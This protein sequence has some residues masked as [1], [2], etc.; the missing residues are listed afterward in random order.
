MQYS[1][2]VEIDGAIVRIIEPIFAA[3]DRAALLQA[4]DRKGLFPT[5]ARLVV[6]RGGER[7]VTLEVNRRTEGAVSA[8]S[9]P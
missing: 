5:E 4:E 7:I 3:N 8:I 9:T 2:L 1:F 6:M